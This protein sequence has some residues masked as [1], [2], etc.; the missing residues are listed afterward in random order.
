MRALRN[1]R[2]VDQTIRLNKRKI[3]FNNWFI[4]RI[5][6]KHIFIVKSYNKV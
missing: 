3:F 2:E 5:S 6:L 4:S 1:V